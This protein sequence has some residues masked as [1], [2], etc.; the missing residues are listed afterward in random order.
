MNVVSFLRDKCLKVK[1][2]GQMVSTY[3]VSQK[4]TIL[5]FRVAVP[6]GIP[7]GKLHL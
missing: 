4:V 3:V 6:F 1:F 7:S 2:L 5:M